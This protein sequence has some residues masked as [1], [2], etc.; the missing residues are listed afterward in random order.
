MRLALRSRAELDAALGLSDDERSAI[1]ALAAAGGLPL[2]VTPHFL[3][4]IDRADANDPLRVQVVPR[5]AELSPSSWDRRDPLGEEELEAVPFLVHR[6]PDRVLLLATDRCASYC[7][8]CTRKRWVGR[9]PGP[10][11]HELEAA[12]AYVEGQPQVRELIVSG[13]DALLLGDDK[14]AWLLAR[15][16]RVPH[17]DV[18]RLATRMLAF[19]PMRVTRQL[20][21]VLRAH[22]EVQG[23][24]ALY[25][26]S[27]FNH[28]RELAPAACAAVS[29]LVD[30][31]VPVL[32]QTVLLR[33]VNDRREVLVALFRAL[34]R[35]RA[36][37][38]YL[39][40]CDLAPGTEAFRV[41]LA[42]AQ[43]LV[44]SLRGELS[45]L[46]VPTF[47]VDVPGGLGKVALSQS[48]QVGDDDDAVVLRG[49]R[50]ELGRYPKR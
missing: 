16:R 1:D 39:H 40:Q 23:A 7:R 45:G 14:L 3:S 43:A 25:L 24:P 12:V 4:L 28:P 26:L 15:V 44:G 2:G 38:Y 41:P 46:S 32:N 19:A 35:L 10:S 31:G 8:F 13:G 42:E 5:G 47:V 37:P 11:A 48:A 18:V 30:A 17:L 22:L 21:G 49:F 20:I 6:Y 50:G 9:G 36:R 34:T 29:A 33:G 27:H